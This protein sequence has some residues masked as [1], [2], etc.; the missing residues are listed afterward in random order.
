MSRSVITSKL[1]V[2][3][4]CVHRGRSH[5]SDR[6]RTLSRTIR[7]LLPWVCVREK[8]W[9]KF[10]LKLSANPIANPRAPHRPP[11]RR[12]LTRFSPDLSEW[13]GYVYC[14]CDRWPNFW[15]NRFKSVLLKGTNACASP[16]GTKLNC[17]SQHF[18]FNGMNA[19]YIFGIFF[20][21]LFSL[22]L[23]SLQKRRHNHLHFS[24]MG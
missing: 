1:L 19:K 13:A 7:S 3:D 15:L 11:I 17:F 12:P 21:Y 22:W 18:N 10:S 23:K 6:E 20:V 14:R 16:R 8:N 2:A 9:I 24:C 5:W 4:C